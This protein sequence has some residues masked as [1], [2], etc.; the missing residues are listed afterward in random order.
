MMHSWAG[1]ALENTS[2]DRSEGLTPDWLVV[3]VVVVVFIFWVSRRVFWFKDNV[4]L[5]K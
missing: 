1:G 2:D 3:V 5:S 4:K